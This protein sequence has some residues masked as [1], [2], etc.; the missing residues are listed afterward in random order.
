[1]CWCSQQVHLCHLPTHSG[2]IGPPCLTPPNAANSFGWNAG[3]VCSATPAFNQG[4]ILM[5]HPRAVA[6]ADRMLVGVDQRIERQPFFDQQRFERFYSQG[7]VRRNRLVTV[8][9]AIVLS[10]G[11]VARPRRFGGVFS[12]LHGISCTVDILRRFGHITELVDATSQI[13]RR[14][15]N[16]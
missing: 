8:I 3:V 2:W 9:V 16:L 11:E 13:T 5:G 14:L 12:S 6:W 7:K 15:G 1:M 4:G 10:V